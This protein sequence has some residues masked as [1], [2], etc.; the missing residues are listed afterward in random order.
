MKGKERTRRERKKKRKWERKRKKEP[1]KYF[2][3]LRRKKALQ[4]D[5]TGILSDIFFVEKYKIELL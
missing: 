1:E 4:G 5:Y 2:C 3:F